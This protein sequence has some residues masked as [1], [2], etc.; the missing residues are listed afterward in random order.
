MEIRR[1]GERK[2]AEKKD[3]GKLKEKHSRK[4]NMRNTNK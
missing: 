2:S 3:K 1:N 4:R